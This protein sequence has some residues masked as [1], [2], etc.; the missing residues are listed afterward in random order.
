ACRSTLEDPRTDNTVKIVVAPKVV[1]A[2]KQRLREITRRSSGRRLTHVAE[3][4]RR[5]VPGWKSYFRLA[6]TP[7]T[8]KDL[9]SWIR[10]RLQALQ[11]K[12]W[13]RG[14]TVYSLSGSPESGGVTRGG[15]LCGQV[16]GG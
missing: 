3:G 6:Q 2:F 15:R 5:F 9:D 1:A 8:F 12:H 4:M 10:H 14:R 11:L 13:R 7:R 16:E